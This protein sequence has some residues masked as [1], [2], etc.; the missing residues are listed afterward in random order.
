MVEH[1]QSFHWPTL[2]FVNVHR[3]PLV[4]GKDESSRK[5][6][7]A[8]YP[9]I[10]RCETNQLRC[11]ST[12]CSNNGVCYIDA[13]SG[14]TTLRCICSIGYTGVNCQSMISSLNPCLSNPC[15]NNGTC[16][17]SSNFSYSCLCPDGLIAQSCAPSTFWHASEII[18]SFSAVL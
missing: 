17:P 10:S 1:V 13:S 8:A 2:T 5:I 6:V 15:G 3:I 4:S 11:T 9:R 14:N 16:S 12:F 18:S 7:F